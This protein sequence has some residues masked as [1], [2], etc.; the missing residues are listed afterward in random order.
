MMKSSINSG[1]SE[2]KIPIISYNIKKFSWYNNNRAKGPESDWDALP[3]G[4]DNID[5]TKTGDLF[6][7]LETR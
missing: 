4:L 6:L 5:F 7:C 2:I 1:V 3:F